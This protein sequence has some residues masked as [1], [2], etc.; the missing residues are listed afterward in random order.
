MDR[1]H[2]NGELRKKDIKKEVILQGWVHRRRDHGGIIFIDLRD[3]YGLTQIVLDPKKIPD[4]DKLRRE[5]VIE[6]KG[7]VRERPNDM[8]NSKLETGEIEVESKS[9]KILNEAEVPPIEIEDWTEA[10]EELRLKY[11]YLDLRRP[12]MQKNLLTR[13]NTAQA[14]REYLSS[15]NF[16]EI[17]TPMFLKTTPGGAKVYKVPSRIH[18][19]K[20]YA[21]PESPQMYK[22]ILMVAG[23]D[24]YFQLARCMRDEDLRADRQPEFTQIDIE[25]SFAEAEDI[26]AI[27]EGLMKNI[28]KTVLKKDLKI[29]FQRFTF[30]D[31]M[32]KYGS[33]K[34]DLRFGLELKNVS[35]IV[36]DC[37]FSIFTNA[38]KK[39]DGIVSCLNAKGCGGFSRTE[40][41]ELIEV[42]KT[43]K[44]SGLAWAKVL[45][46]KME[47]SI[48]KYISEKIQKDLINVVDA[49]DNDLL[50]FAAEEFEKA[51]FALGQVRLHVG[52]KLGLINKD[53]FKFCWVTEFPSFEKND[54]GQWQA[55]HHIFTAPMDEDMD[56][57]EKKPGKVRAKAYDCVLNGTEL[58]GGSVRIHRRDVQTRVLQVTGLKYE[59]AEKRFDFLLNAF[60]YGAPPHGGIA[61]GFDRLCAL[62]CGLED[63]R[64]V[65]AFPKTKSA[66]NPMDGSPQ[67]WTSEFLKELSL[68]LD[69]VKK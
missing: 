30:H 60:R 5:F 58:G 41:E 13:H 14:V 69:V 55:R 48:T 16:M 9:L 11:R 53:E 33:D 67:E 34:P 28:F 8:V 44:L 31:A 59:E 37:E 68:K 1:T 36:K 2:T 64:E 43:Y 47:S 40:I 45:N 39:E 42:A 18:P 15:Q 24:R 51:L 54:A 26:I 62:L 46:G 17:E 52:K 63:I 12:V 56:L 65:I 49:K 29:P 7:N 4:A 38:L 66:E 23:C 25:M 35:K 50:L 57:L 27:V 6:V 61:I 21:L 10:N 3:R 32:L 22:Q 20:F 19:G